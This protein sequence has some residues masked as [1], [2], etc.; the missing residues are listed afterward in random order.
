MELEKIEPK[1]VTLSGTC[2]YCGQ[3]RVVKA[4]EGTSQEDLDK[5]ATDE[6]VCPMACKAFEEKT[7]YTMAADYLKSICDQGREACEKSRDMIEMWNKREALL[8]Y[9]AGLITNGDVKGANIK[10]DFE[11]SISFSMTSS[12][13]LKIKSTYKNEDGQSF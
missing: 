1:F 9:I 7:A 11:N 8:V 3:V 13:K 12:G 4:R 5:I 6:C 10:L 2:K